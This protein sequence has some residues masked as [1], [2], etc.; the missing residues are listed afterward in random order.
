MDERRTERGRTLW[1]QDDDG[2][3]V[4]VERFAARDAA[5]ARPRESG[6]PHHEQTCRIEPAGEAEG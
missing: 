6:A 5:E 4:A 3:R 1:P 2:V